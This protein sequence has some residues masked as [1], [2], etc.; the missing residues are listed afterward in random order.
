MVSHKEVELFERIRRT[1]RR[2]LVRGSMSLGISSVEVSLS[3]ASPVFLFLSADQDI[4][5]SY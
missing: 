2:G 5:L 1:G 4:A 3:H